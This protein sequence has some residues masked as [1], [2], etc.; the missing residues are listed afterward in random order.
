MFFSALA[1]K[2]NDKGPW[3]S[4]GL[5]SLWATTGSAHPLSRGLSQW[6]EN[7]RKT[8]A[9]LLPFYTTIRGRP[10]FTDPGSSTLQRAEDRFRARPISTNENQQWRLYLRKEEYRNNGT[11]A[12]LTF[13]E[14]QHAR[15][16]PVAQGEQTRS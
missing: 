11:L 6:A 8:S 9:T 7:G 14:E 12:V 1:D 13:T 16:W 3:R 10:P 2:S 4:R 5:F 15:N